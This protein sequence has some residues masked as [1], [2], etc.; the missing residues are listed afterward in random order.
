MLHCP[1]SLSI[2]EAYALA[3]IYILMQER[4]LPSNI[5]WA[6]PLPNPVRI[7]E[8]SGTARKWLRDVRPSFVAPD[9]LQQQFTVVWV[10]IG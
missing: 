7:W 10:N 9:S 4:N 5:E 3:T 6:I 2:R 8:F 1:Y